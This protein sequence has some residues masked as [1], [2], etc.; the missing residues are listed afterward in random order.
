MRPRLRSKSAF[1]LAL[2]ALLLVAPSAS[3]GSY[4]V[5]ACGGAAGGAQNAFAGAA[6]GQMAAYNICP[7]VP[8]NPVSGIVTRASATAGPGWV[9]HLAGAYQ[10]FEAPPGASLAS[11]SFDL[12]AIRLAGYWTTGV[13]AYDG[14]FNFGDLPYGCYA[15]TAGCAIGTPSFFGPVT[16]GLNGHSRFRFETRCGNLGGCDISATGFQP[17]VR[18]LFAAANVR[19]RV[20][21]ATPPAINPAGG[22]LWDQGWHRGYEE[23]WEG[24]SDNVGIMGLR[25]RVDGA[26]DESQDYTDAGWPGGVR[27]D[28][29]RRRP[30]NDLTGGVSLDTRSLSDGRHGIR[31]EAVDAAGNESAVE[32]T[33]NVDNTPPVRVN[34]SVEGGEGWRRT[35]DFTVRWPSPS[36]QVAP[37]TK[38]HYRLCALGA[39][40][41]CTNGSQSRPGVENLSHIAVPGP[42]DYT[43]E[44]WLEDAAGNTDP[45]SA[46]DPV[47]LRFDDTPPVAL[48]ELLD[49][50]EPLKLEARAVDATSGLA[51]GTIELRHIGYRQWHPL[52]TSL[53]GS[54]LLAR[55]PDL[56]LPDGPYE[57]RVH[58]LDRA[59]N[60]ADGD[61]RADG[62]RMELTLPLRS[63]SHITLS[64][65]GTPRRRCGKLKH[66]HRKRRCR[67]I[68]GPRVYRGRRAKQIRGALR[69]ANGRPLAGSSITVLEQPRTGGGFRSVGTLRSDSLGRF[70][71]A[72]GRGP[73][74]TVLFRYEG[75]PLVKPATASARVAV[76]ARTT[77]HTSRKSLR[78]GQSVRFTGRLATAPVPRGGKLIDLQAY[79]RGKWRTFATPR[80]DDRGGWAFSYR[81]GATRGLVT[82]RFRARIRREAAYPF[83]LGYSRVVAVTVRG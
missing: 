69:T 60:E 46:S 72:L 1:G 33:I 66:G 68:H 67:A 59:G 62:A 41:T 11:V 49:E 19:V 42:G 32:R 18:A 51:A 61:R 65:A 77:I 43:L 36:R 63:P 8:S 31:V 78:N 3:A 34:A 27:C 79:Y 58:V 23:A 70:S 26:V 53:E 74:R 75:T 45:A 29:T 44:V 15:G 56:E 40:P 14:D 2:A 82:Y 64:R 16:V 7:N 52:A 13:V 17:G 57:F 6:D 35:N 30:C 83:E 71:H 73:S 9:P 4:E 76:P 48:F 81:F 50:N 5:V 39:G 12:A 80:T 28:F 20:Q 47:R 25:L 22:A 10:I 38:A 21:D 37:L 54:L 55:I 24:L